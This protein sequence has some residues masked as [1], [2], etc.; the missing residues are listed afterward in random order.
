[1]KVGI[2]GTGNMAEALAKAWQRAGHTVVIGGRSAQKAAALAVRLGTG[3]TA[4]P[5]AE[6]PSGA[7]AVVLA[8]SW[9]GIDE[10]LSQAGAG[11]GNLSGATLIDCTNAID[12]ATGVLK[13]GSGSAAEHVAQRA[14]GAHVV[15][16]LHLYAGQSW[17]TPSPDGAPPR[18]VAM[19]G[20]ESAALEVTGQL[21]RDLGGKPVVLGGLDRSRQL[22]D[23]AGFVVRLVGLG[24]NP[25]TA[26][27]AVAGLS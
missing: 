23:V 19:C 9:E 24:V 8:V 17:L 25:V 10:L 5:P 6:V 13:P 16:A 27:P 21:I 26:I 2:L 15:K 4:A 14:P 20:D 1:M 12:F 11:S 7:D 18:V 22:E 3:V